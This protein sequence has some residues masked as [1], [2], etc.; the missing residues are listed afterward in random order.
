MPR[1]DEMPT[2]TLPFLDFSSGYVQRALDQLPRQHR[3]KP[4]R[5]N[6]SYMSDL[7]NLRFGK[8]DDGVLEFQTAQ[9]QPDAPHAVAIEGS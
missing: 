6:Q 9:E 4:W 8:I 5:L 3:D 2:D 1:L 7:L